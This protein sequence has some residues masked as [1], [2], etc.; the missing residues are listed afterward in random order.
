MEKEKYLKGQSYAD[1][2][3]NYND[4]KMSKR[5]LFLSIIDEAKKDELEEIVGEL[6]KE[7]T[8]CKKQG[9]KHTANAF[10]AFVAEIKYNPSPKG[11]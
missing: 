6:L 9:L 8:D 4:L 5:D 11:E 7:A 10:T 1:R 3:F 2:F